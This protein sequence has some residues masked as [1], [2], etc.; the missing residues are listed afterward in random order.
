[1]FTI[2]VKENTLEMASAAFEVVKEVLDKKPNAVLGLATGSSP[3]GLYKK[4]IEDHKLTGRSYKDVVTFNLDEY[5][6]LDR[7]HSQSYYTFMKEH[8]FDF[9]DI[10]LK[11]VHIPNGNADD[12]DAEVKRYEE[13]L[14]K[15]HVDVQVMGIGSNGHIGFNEPGTPFSAT[16]HI[17]ALKES[18]R[19]DNARFF[20]SID[21]VPTHAVTMGIASIMKAKK[22]VLLASTSYKAKAIA[23]MIHGPVT[24]KC[25]AS[26]L[27]QHPDVV[28]II[29]KAAASLLADE[30]H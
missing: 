29:D 9:I 26:V 6:H 7:N 21:D 11:N 5:V 2:I 10:D 16:T 25:P 17:E 20:A 19:N 12:F 18:T 27:Q 23:A 8:L 4:M 1:M 14:S 24:E 13:E 30:G 3:I 28:V 15:F 22:I